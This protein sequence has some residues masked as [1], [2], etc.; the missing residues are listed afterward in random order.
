MSKYWGYLVVAVLAFLVGSA[1]VVSAQTVEKFVITNE[2]GTNAAK[3]NQA[4]RL[5][6]KVSNLPKTQNV[7][8]TNVADLQGDPGDPGQACWDLNGNGVPDVGT[9]DTNGDTNVDIQDCQGAPGEDHSDFVDRF[10]N[11]NTAGG[12]LPAGAVPTAVS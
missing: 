9:E 7:R 4:G 1:V 3:V 10:G 6:V 11:A 12:G 8:I 2:A 5:Q